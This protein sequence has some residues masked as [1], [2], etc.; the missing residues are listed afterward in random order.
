[1]TLYDTVWSCNVV[2][3]ER[4]WRDR[5]RLTLPVVWSTAE[6]H[7]CSSGTDYH[8]AQETSAGQTITPLP[9]WS[10]R[11]SWATVSYIGKPRLSD[12]SER[13]Y[14]HIYTVLIG[15]LSHVLRHNQKSDKV[16]WRV[17]VVDKVSIKILSTCIKMHQLNKEGIT[18]EL[19]LPS[20][21]DIF[22]FTWS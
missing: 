22:I 11:L 2:W 5:Y 16:D 9:P 13:I 12:F 18:R 21:E 7:Q 3:R 17:L 1:M 20:V 15:L 10:S 6:Q 19:I 4:G 8:R 14:I